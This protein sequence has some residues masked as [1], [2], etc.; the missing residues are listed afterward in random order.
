VYADVLQAYTASIQRIFLFAVPVAAAAFVL[1][2]F[3]REVPLRKTAGAA[4]LAEGLGAASAQ[5]SSV[6]EI[7]RALLRLADGDLCRADYARMAELSGL[8]LPAG[9][10]WVLA[11]L[12]KRGPLAGADLA[13]E[14]G[15]SVE[16]GRPYTDRLVQAGYCRR[17][18][19]T[20]YLTDAGLA[21]A[22]R[23]F[24]ARREGLERLLGEWSPDQHADLA[25]MLDKLSRALLGE[26]ADRRLI[27]AAPREAQADS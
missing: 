7:E 14:A 12:A 23:L 10:C 26:D 22:D 9:S 15:G 18:A 16:Q 13:R 11:R 27:A 17:D 3:L 25:Q 2:W 21:A 1:T 6:A 5:R 4:D 8:G 19:D 20:L 24:A